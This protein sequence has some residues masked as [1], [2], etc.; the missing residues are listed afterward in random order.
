M[1][2]WIFIHGAASM[3]LTGDYDLTEEQTMQLLEEN[4][5]AWL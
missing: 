2:M 1:R 5:H 4:Y 3:T